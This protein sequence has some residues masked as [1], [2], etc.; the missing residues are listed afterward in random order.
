[1]TDDS[2]FVGALVMQRPDKRAEE[3]IRVF[4]AE[5]LYASFLEER[6]VT[7]TSYHALL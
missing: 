2:Q 4:V 1:M 5:T 7:A 3:W 6:C